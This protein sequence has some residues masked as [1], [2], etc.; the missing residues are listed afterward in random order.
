MF[1]FYNITYMHRKL[2]FFFL[3]ISTITYSQHTD[4]FKQ[5]TASIKPID[6]V[7]IDKKFSNGKTKEIGLIKT[8]E[9]G[10]YYYDVYSGKRT[11]YYR[12]R[13][14]KSVEEFD[15]F[16]N[17]ISSQQYDN[18][19]FPYCSNRTIEIDTKA[20]N[21]SDFF[22]SEE[23]LSITMSFKKYRISLISGKWFLLEEGKTINGEMVGQWK[24]YNKDGSIKEVTEH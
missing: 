6:S 13:E 11:N 16:G 1:M 10:D 4:R 24:K 3:L 15:S 2:I 12:S 5:F 18:E 21:L 19:S 23:H 7:V 9:Y 22:E 20:K 14:L 17:L 8:Y